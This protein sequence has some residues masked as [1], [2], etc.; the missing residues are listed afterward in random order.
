MK[1]THIFMFLFSLVLVTL[2]AVLLA[3]VLVP[4]GSAMELEVEPNELTEGRSG[5]LD[6][7]VTSEHSEDLH[8]R[9][10]RGREDF[11]GILLLEDNISVTSGQ[12]WKIRFQLTPTIGENDLFVAVT[13]TTSGESSSHEAIWGI[14][15]YSDVLLIINNNSAISKEIGEYFLDFYDPNVLYVDAPTK[16]TISRSEFED[17]RDQIEEHLVN[18]SLEDDINYLVTTKGVPLRVSGTGNAAFDSELTLIL[19]RYASDIGGGSYRYNPFHNDTD[20]FSRDEQDIYLV[21]RLT[22]YTAADAKGIIDRSVAAFTLEGLAELSNGTTILDVD[23]A[24]N[25]GGSKSGNDWLR[26]SASLQIPKGYDVYLDKTNTFVRHQE[27][28]SF[29]AS[30][31]SNDGHDF[32]AHGTNTGMETDAGG[33]DIPDGW[34]YEEGSG[35][36]TRTSEDK[37]NGNWAVRIVRNEDTG[38]SSLLQQ[39]TPEPGYRYYI[40]GY[41]NTTGVAGSGGVQ[42]VFLH[43]DMD[44]TLIHEASGAYRRGTTSDF[45]SLGTCHLE[46][47]EGTEYVMF[48][49]RLKAAEGTV[50]LDDI[51]LVEIVPNNDYLDG[52]LAETIVSTGA[53]SFSYPTNYGQSLIADIIRAGVTGIKG[54]CYEPYLDAIAH[55]NILF[56]RYTA[57]WN[58]A[59]SYYAASIKLSWMDVVVGVPKLAP[60]SLLPDIAITGLNVMQDP[61]DSMNRTIRVTVSNLGGS[62]SPEWNLTISLSNET[63]FW[64]FT[65]EGVSLY[66]GESKGFFLNW[67]APEPNTFDLTVIASQSGFEQQI[68]NNIRLSSIEVL[69][70]PDLLVVDHDLSPT[71]PQENMTFQ[72]TVTVR[73]TGESPAGDMNVSLFIDGEFE[74]SLIIDVG[75]QEN[76]FGIFTDLVL[77]S[78]DHSYEIIVDQENDIRESDDS[79]NEYQFIARINDL[80]DAIITGPSTTRVGQEIQLVGSLSTDVD[81]TIAQYRWSI[82]G[83]H[84]IGEEFT[85]TFDTRGTFPVELTVVDNDDGESIVV[86]NVTV[87]NT[88]PVA[89]F[90]LP[91]ENLLTYENYTFDARPSFDN[92]TISLNYSWDFGD[93]T[94]ADRALKTKSYRLPGDYWITLTMEDDV[95]ATSSLSREITIGNRPPVIS[96][97][98]ECDGE[99]YSNVVLDDI[100]CPTHA[101]I[102][103]NLSGSYDPD[104]SI[105]S[106]AFEDGNDSP[107]LIGFGIPENRTFSRTYLTSGVISINITFF[108]DQETNTSVFFTISI[109]NPRPIASFTSSPTAPSSFE[110]IS[111]TSTSSDNG[112]IS[113]YLWDM[114][115]TT[116]DV[117]N[118]THS[119]D[120]YGFHV[121]TLTVTDDEGL[122]NEVQEWI[123]VSNLP[124]EISAEPMIAIA[125]EEVQI[126]VNA[127]DPEDGIA[128]YLFE[129]PDGQVV[130]LTAPQ[131]SM[132]FP[133]PGLYFLNVSVVDDHGTS[134]IVTVEII[135][136]QETDDSS[137]PIG[138]TSFLL[139]FLLIGVLVSIGIIVVSK[140]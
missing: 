81:G 49:A 133:E 127:S 121:V 65:L 124:P 11:G 64:N 53:R 77:P 22:G 61:N 94:G 92:D 80:P 139:V 15:D 25:G 16:T 37:R 27:N 95:G 18:S 28:V 43:Y 125:G 39:F 137:L 85:H 96:I 136:V 114:E 104:G 86:E 23:P 24:R 20:R 48:G 54:Y 19:G 71:V 105:V 21:T 44:D 74:A 26:A 84:Y 52:S 122:T 40:Q 82:E 55:P 90:S 41:A 113:S 8:V 17:V 100:S 128:Y 57:G 13:G 46:P 89:E 126:W 93:G 58:L 76:A 31:G 134:S 47:I 103:F 45:V 109:N 50:Y 2:L 68:G 129:L 108:D 32:I 63:Q 67:T 79:N 116:Y 10:F 117:P 12:E 56:D 29:Y 4:S 72:L 131:A 99:T 111:F 135:A 60:F 98:V 132:T 110:L 62:R 42:L 101:P 30:W 120:T 70:Q 97:E 36:M 83:K 33:D 14:T 102:L 35:D 66:A 78:G 91:S 112:V 38:S 69:S 88:P 73:N 3:L 115:G 118:P 6:L 7:S 123:Y 87:E 75:G 140:K 119:F 51:R 9:V 106:F 59:E 1:V 130:N 107:P 34:T 5:N 138:N